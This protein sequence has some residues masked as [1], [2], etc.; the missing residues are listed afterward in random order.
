MYYKTIVLELIQ[1]FPETYDRLK[2][3]RTLLATLERLA[4]ELKGNHENWTRKLAEVS[5]NHD[6]QQIASNAAWLSAVNRAIEG[7]MESN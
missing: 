5:P 6:E 1:Q 4:T 3:S 2:V 7:V